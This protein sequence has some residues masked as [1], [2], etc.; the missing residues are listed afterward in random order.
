MSV[1]F[2]KPVATGDRAQNL[3]DTKDTLVAVAKQRPDLAAGGIA[4]DMIRW[5][6]SGSK[7]EIFN[8][9]SWVDLAST[10][11]IN[12]SSFNGQAASYYTNITARLGYTPVNKAGDTMTGPLVL[13]AAPSAA[14][15]AATKGY[16]D[17]GLA[18]KAN[19]AHTHSWTA[20]T[21]RN[22]SEGTNSQDPNSAA[23]PVIVTNHANSPDSSYYWHITTTYYSTSGNVAQIA[24]QY[25]DSNRVYARSRYG[26]TWTSWVRCDLGEGLT[27]S[28]GASGYLKLPGAGGLMIQWGSISHGG[29]GNVAVSF[30]IAF[31]NAAVAVV[32]NSVY[33]GGA[34][35]PS[36]HSKSASGFTCYWTG[37][38]TITID[39]IAIGY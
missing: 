36:A 7:W 10:F 27:R 32:P 13:N 9:T 28:I 11:A 31:P 8:G 19:S 5:S 21:D 34:N 39:Y 38:A 15:G 23:Y 2:T 29:G 14:L 16:V 33:N 24:V 35:N 20:I 1:D 6:S 4:A 25:S 17:T 12:V 37:G 3:V 26:G 30:P 18:G 22:M